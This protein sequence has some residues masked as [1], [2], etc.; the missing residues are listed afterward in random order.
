MKKFKIAIPIL[1]LS[2][3]TLF[4]CVKEPVQMEEESRTKEVPQ[5]T[6]ALTRSSTI[7][8]YEILPNPYAL[9]VMQ[10]VYDTYSETAVILQPTDLYVKFMPKDSLELHTLIY[11]YDL[12]LF[13]HP[14]DIDLPEGEEYINHN[15]PE[16]DLTWVY[17][18]V[19]PDFAFPSGISYEIIEECYIPDNGETIGIPTKGGEIDVEDAAFA[20]MGYNELSSTSTQTLII[21]QG[22]IN[23]Y[24]NDIESNVPVKGV[25]V[26]CHNFVKRATAY[27]DEYGSYIMDI[28]FKRNPSYS[29][30]FENNKDFKIWGIS[31]G[32]EYSMG[33]HGDVN[34]GFDNK[35]WLWAV[36]N[37]AAYEYYK[38]CEETGILKP[39]PNLKIWVWKNAASSSAPMLSRV[40]QDVKG[41]IQ[42]FFFDIAVEGLNIML[43][44]ITPDITIGGERIN[45]IPKTYGR[46]YQTVHHELAHA[47]HYSQAGAF[48]WANYILYIISC[49]GYGDGTEDQAQL[50]GIGEMWGNYIGYAQSVNKYS[51]STLKKM[52]S[53]E[54]WIYPQVFWRLDS[55]GILS[56]KQI[57][58]CLT[59][60]VDTYNELVNKMYSL[61][62]D[63]AIEIE[64]VFER[65]PAINHDVSL[66]AGCVKCIDQNYTSS[67]FING[68]RIYVENI[69]V[70]NGSCLVLNAKSAITIYEPFTIEGGAELSIFL[71]I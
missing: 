28:S 26:R 49:M 40:I 65:Y 22:K 51:I 30:V 56:K 20:L 8:A 63:K 68:D 3:Y 19:S 42:N 12:E 44:Y 35:A 36:V 34:L 5:C 37:N 4:S 52:G 47:S 46:I 58:D 67:T 2:C 69:T 41:P 14:L 27:T 11:D 50:C 64:N 13:S 45:G 38:M 24:D 48:Y 18:T 17:T 59:S 1:L 33:K 10:K 29:I 9:D 54:G 53:V 57:Y 6:N 23:V 7:K 32:S 25:K 39:P 60:E 31:L 16:S 70:G 66:P 61:Y 43:R 55:I 21:P 62:P 15:I 71:G